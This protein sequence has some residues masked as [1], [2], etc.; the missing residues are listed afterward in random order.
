MRQGVTDPCR[1]FAGCL[2]KIEFFEHKDGRLVG[3]HD[4]RQPGYK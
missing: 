4:N 3:N 2:K 1:G